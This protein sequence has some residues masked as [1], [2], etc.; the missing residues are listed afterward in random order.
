[1]NI[2]VIDF[3]I[4]H[5]GTITAESDVYYTDKKIVKEEVERLNKKLRKTNS[6][7]DVRY[8]YRKL[9]PRI[10]TNVTKVQFDSSNLKAGK[11]NGNTESLLIKFTSGSV[12]KYDD[13]C[14][15]EFAALCGAESQ[16]SYFATNIKP[17]KPCTRIK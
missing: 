15:E 10:K 13:V 6:C 2:Y 7:M 9:S 11:Y 8:A 3:Y 4:K 12:Y 5:E 17:N 16:G 14:R 1:M